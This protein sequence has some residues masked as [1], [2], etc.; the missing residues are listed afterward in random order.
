MRKLSLVLAAALFFCLLPVANAL[1]YQDVTYCT[2]INQSHV[3]LRVIN[4][5]FFSNVYGLNHACFYP[6][7]T[8][9]GNACNILPSDVTI[10]LQGHT[11]YMNGTNASADWGY[12]FF[13]CNT[14][15]WTIMNG[16]VDFSYHLGDAS[17]S[18][19][20]LGSSGAFEPK[21]MTVVNVHAEGKGKAAYGLMVGSGAVALTVKYS[22]FKGF[23]TCDTWLEIAQGQITSCSDDYDLQC[24]STLSKLDCA[25]ATTSVPFQ[26]SEPI[27]QINKA[28]WIAN[29]YGW[30]LVFFT[31]MFIYTVGMGGASAVLARVGGYLVGAVTALALIFV[32]TIFQVYPLWVGITLL[33]LAGF[34]VVYFVTKGTTGG[35]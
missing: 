29:G 15:D 35:G 12:A 10:D 9:G 26:S 4:D 20:M 21:N 22:S 1:T 5:V 30:L 33:I 18:G 24:G 6:S 32:Y 13:P 7:V 8:L 11:I 23:N 27:P 2:N 17:M 16:Y 28:A 31:P 19:F 25:A 34:V 3:Y 14:T